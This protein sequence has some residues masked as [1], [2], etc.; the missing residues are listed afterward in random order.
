METGWKEANGERINCRAPLMDNLL[1]HFEAV[2]MGTIG[3][4]VSLAMRP[5]RLMAS[6]SDNARNPE[7]STLKVS[8]HLRALG[9]A[10]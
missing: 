5:D 1:A 9:R 6:S 3:Q 4:D 10:L 8:H 2:G 7:G